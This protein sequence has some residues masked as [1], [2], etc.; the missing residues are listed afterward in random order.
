MHLRQ[1]LTAVA[2]ALALWQQWQAEPSAAP[3]CA[4]LLADV[5]D[6]KTRVL[7]LLTLRYGETIRT[8]RRSLASGEGDK[9]A[10]ALEILDTTLPQAIKATVWPLV[11]TMPPAERW[12]ACPAP[13]LPSPLAQVA[14]II[15]R[16]AVGHKRVEP[17]LCALS[18]STNPA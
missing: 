17:R 7:D 16:T 10:Y 11:Q 13:P 12:A 18:H 6:A 5:A 14:R 1:E 4:A 3:F 2:R 15:G 8:A 9:V